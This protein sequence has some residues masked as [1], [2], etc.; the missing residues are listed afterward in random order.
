LSGG[1]GQQNDRAGK[2]G[3]HHYDLNLK[4]SLFAL[5]KF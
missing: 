5:K 2:M 4:S 1:S 3:E